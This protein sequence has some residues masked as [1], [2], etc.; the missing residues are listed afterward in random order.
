M[1]FYYRKR[2]ALGRSAHVN[3]SKSGAS[4]SARAGRVTVNSRGR[5]SVRL[6]PGLSYRVGGSRRKGLFG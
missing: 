2:A 1:P 3:L 6:L 4:V 5:V